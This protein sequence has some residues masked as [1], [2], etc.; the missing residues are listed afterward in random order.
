VYYVQ[1]AHARIWSVIGYATQQIPWWKRLGPVALAKLSAPEER[2]LLRQLLQFPMVASS[3]AV[4]LEPH[5][6][7][8]HLQRLAEA[9]HIFYD[10]RRVVSDDV[11][12]SRARIALIEA[13]GRVLANGLRMLGVS[14]PKHM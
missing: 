1:Y 9:F 3:C 13:A 8:A 5:G 14:A 4:A 2:L 7:T 6:L 10:K 11:A 12:T